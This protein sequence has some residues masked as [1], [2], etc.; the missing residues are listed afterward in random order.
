MAVRRDLASGFYAVPRDAVTVNG[1]ALPQL[2]TM[3][4]PY[5]GYWALITPNGRAIDGESG[6]PYVYL[7]LE[8]VTSAAKQFAVSGNY[9]TCGGQLSDNVC[10]FSTEAVS[11]AVV[12]EETV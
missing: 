5:T 3:I 9:S 7:S 10:A 2:N 4:E 11:N 1:M 12:D 6:R 8:E